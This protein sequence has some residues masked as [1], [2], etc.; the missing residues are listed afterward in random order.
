MNNELTLQKVQ[1]EGL[2]FKGAG[3][4]QIKITFSDFKKYI[5]QPSKNGNEISDQQAITLFTFCWMRGLNPIERDAYITGFENSDGTTSWEIIVS[6]DAFLKRADRN[7]DYEGEQHGIIVMTK[8]GKVIEREGEYMLPGEQL[9][10]GW[11]IVYRK[12]RKPTVK[13]IDINDY[14]RPNIVWSKKATMLI[15]KCALVGALRAAF[16]QTLSHLYIKEETPEIELDE[17]T[18]ATISAT[19]IKNG[20]GSLIKNKSTQAQEATKEQI[21]EPKPVETVQKIEVQHKSIEIAQPIKIQNKPIEVPTTANPQ[22]ESVEVGTP[23]FI[24]EQ[25]PQ[26]LIETEGIAINTKQQEKNENNHPLFDSAAP[27]TTTN[28]TMS[29]HEIIKSQIRE[30][31][32]TEAEFLN[33]F[34]NELK[35]SPVDI[36]ETI[37]KINDNAQLIRIKRLTNKLL[38]NK[39]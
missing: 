20:M 33:K 32:M 23:E 28:R 35:I 4:D 14:R 12:G 11:A 36:P 18:E 6:R 24:V 34:S 3:N 10:G 8:D 2:V 1:N 25:L 15:A 13:K 16:P 26:D 37:D 17:N 38:Q 21:I 7:P 27:Q 22:Q 30:L 39:K 19:E 31:G 29:I 5:C 9:I